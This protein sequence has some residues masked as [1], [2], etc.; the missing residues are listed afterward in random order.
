MG[1]RLH[2]TLFGCKRSEAITQQTVRVHAPVSGERKSG[3][4]AEVLTPDDDRFRGHYWQTSPAD[5]APAPSFHTEIR[6]HKVHGTYFRVKSPLD[7][8]SGMHRI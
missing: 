4:P 5:P 8:C 6:V 1:S 2:I 7:R 3:I